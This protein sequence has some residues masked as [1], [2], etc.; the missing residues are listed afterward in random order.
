LGLLGY[1]NLLK[2][3]LRLWGFLKEKRLDF[4]N[5]VNSALGLRNYYNYNDNEK[6]FPEHQCTMLLTNY[7][8]CNDIDNVA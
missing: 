8:D 1:P 7:N 6:I 4:L 2:F 3:F 5:I